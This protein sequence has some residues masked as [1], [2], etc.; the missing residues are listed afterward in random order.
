MSKKKYS[1]ELRMKVAKEAAKP[2]SKGMEHI[3]HKYEQICS[4]RYRILYS[5]IYC[6]RSHT[7]QGEFEVAFILHQHHLTKTQ[8]HPPCR[9]P[10]REDAFTFP[11]FYLKSRTDSPLSFDDTSSEPHTRQS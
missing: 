6:K 5:W 8:K 1:R 4:L 10:G 2:E 9:F 3:K 11:I 7:F